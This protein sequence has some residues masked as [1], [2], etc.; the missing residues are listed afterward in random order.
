MLQHIFTILIFGVTDTSNTERK[1][2]GLM[3]IQQ[4]A[5][6]ITLVTQLKPPSFLNLQTWMFTYNSVL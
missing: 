2:W 6:A 4:A 3:Q 1:R 5:E